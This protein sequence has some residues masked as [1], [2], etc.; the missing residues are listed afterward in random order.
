MD[1][2][3][4]ALALRVKAPH[5]LLPSTVRSTAS[6]RCSLTHLISSRTIHP[7]RLP[8]TTAYKCPMPVQ[9]L[10]CP[11]RPYPSLVTSSHPYQHTALRP[12][13]N[14]PKLPSTLSASLSLPFCRHRQASTIPPG[15]IL[16]QPC[17]L[18]IQHQKAVPTIS[19]GICK[20]QAHQWGV[21]PILP[22]AIKLKL[23]RGKDTSSM[24]H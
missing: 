4:S 1:R 10:S 20:A 21:I 3:T 19:C 18:Q 13:D 16:I 5:R 8:P 23:A 7:N 15:L 22:W 17:S 2:L 9:A 6:L 14:R 12:L 24:V 11:L